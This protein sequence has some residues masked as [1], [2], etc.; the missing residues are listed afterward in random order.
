MQSFLNRKRTEPVSL[1]ELE[2]L[3]P[4]FTT[5]MYDSLENNPISQIIQNKS[6]AI[7][8]YDMH[9]RNGGKLAVGHFS[10]ILK[11]GGKLEYFSSYGF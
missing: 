6:G 1:E 11:E 3:L 7:L 10:L 9:S 2:E 4:D 8:Y 5:I